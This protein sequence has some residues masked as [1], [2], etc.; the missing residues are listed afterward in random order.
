MPEVARPN[1]KAGN[2]H[3]PVKEK[4]VT[5]NAEK[6]E[7]RSSRPPLLRFDDPCEP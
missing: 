3:L 5:F 6:E 4:S 7:V 2:A 1:V